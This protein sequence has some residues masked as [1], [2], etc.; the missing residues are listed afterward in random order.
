MSNVIDKEELW[1]EEWFQSMVETMKPRALS[2]ELDRD[3]EDDEANPPNIYCTTNLHQNECFPLLYIQKNPG[4]FRNQK[5]F[6]RIDMSL[7]TLYEGGSQESEC[8]KHLRKTLS[9]MH[10][11]SQTQA[12]FHLKSFSSKITDKKIREVLLSYDVTII[13]G[14][15]NHKAIN[16]S[17]GELRIFLDDP[18]PWANALLH[19]TI[20]SILPTSSARHCKQTLFT[21]PVESR[22]DGY[23]AYGSGQEETYRL[24]E[25]SRAYEKY[26]SVIECHD[27]APP[28]FSLLWP[29]RSLWIYSAIPIREHLIKD[30]PLHVRYTPVPGTLVFHD[31]Q[32]REHTL[33]DTVWNHQDKTMTHT[34]SGVISYRPIMHMEVKKMMVSCKESES[35]SA[36][37]LELREL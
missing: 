27:H 22:G 16:T 10:Q 37:S 5:L 11:G 2:L 29:H 15:F 23:R 17:I 18:D 30:I 4:T 25:N 19:R 9:A 26:H 7:R 28:A 33:P 3:S 34:Q 20:P 8:L 6:L 21:S 31:E 32:E 1:F 35:M 13:W 24:D 36:W 14:E 12:F